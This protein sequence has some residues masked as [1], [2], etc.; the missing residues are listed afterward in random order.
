MSDIQYVYP[1]I[2]NNVTDYVRM[3]LNRRRRHDA[4]AGKAPHRM[5]KHPADCALCQQGS[6]V[7][8]HMYMDA[9]RQ[10][11]MASAT[12]AVKDRLHERYH[13]ANGADAPCH[14]CGNVQ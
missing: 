8:E 5:G 12:R 13:L 10:A 2:H 14:R 3:V 6:P 7:A 11:R 1:L 9:A 4:E